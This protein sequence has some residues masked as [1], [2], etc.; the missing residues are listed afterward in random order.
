MPNN[1]MFLRV[2]YGVGS[3]AFLCALFAVD[4]YVALRAQARNGAF[5][6]LWSRGSLVPLA[7]LATYLAAAIELVF[8]LRRKGARPAAGLAVPIVILLILSPWLTGAG[9]FGTCA[10]DF[11]PFFV[12]GM[13]L[14]IGSLGAAAPIVLR[15]TTDG[16][17][18]DV[19]A[20]YVILLYG[21]FLASFPV[22]IRS[23]DEG[24]AGTWYL[25]LVVLVTKSADIGAYFAGTL[26]GRRKLIPEV[27]PSKS[28]E[29]LIGGL[30]ASG[31][32]AAGL[33][34][35]AGA[36]NNLA[37]HGEWPSDGLGVMTSLAMLAHA[38][39]TITILRAFLFGVI[40]A[41]A[42]QLGDLFESCCKRDA[43]VKDSGRFMPTYGG[44]WDLMDSLIV[45]IPVGWLMLAWV[46]GIAGTGPRL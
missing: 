17:L 31:I 29:G 38:D 14:L 6:A 21:G 40:L 33:I 30:L 5:A 46:F 22:M 25:L 35:A 44:L 15:R 19:G 11:G 37:Q 10:A 2:A 3:I 43:A 9:W 45:A 39:T 36:W 42:G 27:S 12:S 13:L 20:N 34:T 7:T 18:R 1:T 26:L 28:V 32:A 8:I 41:A 16:A 24:P 4:A 23:A